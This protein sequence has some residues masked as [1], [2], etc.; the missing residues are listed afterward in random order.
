MIRLAPLLI[1]VPLL[2]GPCSAAPWL[3]IASRHFKLLTNAGERNGRQLLERLET[4]RHVFGESIGGHARALPVYVF[5]FAS[6]REFRRFEPKP[7]VRGFHQG[8]ADRDYIAILGSGEEA[9]RAVRHEYMHLLLGHGS[10]TLP[11]WLEEGTAELYSTVELR[12]SGAVFGSPV[13]SHVGALASFK[14]IEGDTFFAATRNSPLLEHGNFAGVFYAQAWALAHMLNFSPAWRRNMPRF[15]ESLDQGTPALPA[16]EPAFGLAPERALAELRNYIRGARFATA[17]VPIPPRPPDADS[18][19]E[20]VTGESI[21]LAH[22]ELL[23]ALGRTQAADEL[24]SSITGAPTPEI[25]TARGLQALA[26]KNPGEAKERF[27]AAMRLGDHTGVPAFEYAMILRDEHAADADVRRYLAEAVGRNPSFAEAHFILG[28]MAQRENRHRDAVASFEEALRVQPRQSPFWHARAM[29]HLELKQPEL[30]RRSALRAA[31]SAATNAQL[32]M[33]QAALK[34]V[35]ATPAAASTR[36]KPV[37]TVPDSWKPRQGAA[38][39][40]GQLEQIDCYGASARFQV[41]P[42]ASSAPVRLWVD[43]PGDVL[44]KDVSSLS[45]TFACGPQQPRKVAIE[46]DPQPGLPQQ[47]T[48]RIT[49]IHF[50]P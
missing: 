25:E 22:V 6:E 9:L 8:A 47:S 29:S 46:Y 14:W 45:F 3:R 4:V 44:L 7:A 32:D 18:P 24:L 40:E 5:Q 33:A 2:A 17:V 49:A 37:V 21:Q 28:L 16:F 38:S 39:V 36:A 11:M 23:L 10:A 20:Q 41:R 50:Q 30:A 1:L 26:R 35:A 43:K 48:G 19:A 12:P 13:R 27:T 31:A 34:L 15:V 42:S